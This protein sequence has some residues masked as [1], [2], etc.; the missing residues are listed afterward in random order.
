VLAL[1]IR[2]KA[3]NLVNADAAKVS[4]LLRSTE[5][6]EAFHCCLDKVDGSLGPEALA[7]HVMDS[8]KFKYRANATTGNYAGTW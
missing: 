2:V 4:D 6:T 8:G 7:E 5:A 3:K 1:T